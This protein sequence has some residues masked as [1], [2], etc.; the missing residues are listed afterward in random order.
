MKIP[1]IIVRVLM[2]LMFLF[3]SVSYFLQLFPMPELTGDV[4]TFMEGVMATG[5][6]MTLIKLT[7]FICGLLFVIGRYVA[8]ATVAI[9]PITL[10]IMLYHM[11]IAPEGT[12]TA[13]L[14]IVGN[15]FLVYAYRK[16][17]TGLFT[18]K[19]IE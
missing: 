11:S 15:L 13:V 7:E 3:A 19:R 9:F 8:F 14:L 18:A 10:N 12:I 16:H 5:Y 2:G 4:K 1:V 6:L 17:Y